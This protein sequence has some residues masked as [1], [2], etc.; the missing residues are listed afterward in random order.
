MHRLLPI[1]L[2]AALAVQGSCALAET[3]YKCVSSNG[4]VAYS[5][6]PCDGQAREAKQFAVPPPESDEDSRER[7]TRERNK[8]RIADMQFRQRQAERN[9]GYSGAGG[10]STRPTRGTASEQRRAQRDKNLAERAEA[11]R[12]NAARIG[13]CTMRRPEA[14]CL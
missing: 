13:N 6:L 1:A 3:M 7:V 10:Y 12:L 8:L 5:S 9:A 2:A 11:A 4:K 14:N